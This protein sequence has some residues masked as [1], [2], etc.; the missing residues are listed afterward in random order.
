[1]HQLI[2]IAGSISKWLVSCTFITFFVLSGIDILSGHEPLIDEVLIVLLAVGWF[3]FLVSK[4]TPPPYL[5]FLY[6]FV[7]FVVIHNVASFHLKREETTAFLL[8]L[9]SLLTSIVLLT[10]EMVRSLTVSLLF[11]KSGRKRHKKS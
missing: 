2:R 11:P 6:L 9:L 7:V 8:A 5:I 3:I 10:I 4:K 1:M